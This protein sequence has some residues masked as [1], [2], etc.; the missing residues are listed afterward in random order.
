MSVSLICDADITA[1]AALGGG[2]PSPDQQYLWDRCKPDEFYR[3]REGDSARVQCV[4]RATKGVYKRTRRL[5][6]KEVP[7]TGHKSYQSLSEDLVSSFPRPSVLIP[8]I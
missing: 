6:N 7:Q 1:L 4:L 8:Q 2:A 3:G 5:L